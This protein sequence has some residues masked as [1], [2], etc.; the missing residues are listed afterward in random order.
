MENS[1]VSV[2]LVDDDEQYAKVVGHLLE[3]VKDRRFQMIWK[4][5]GEDGLQELKSN[6]AIDVV[7]MDYFLPGM[8][9]LE[10]VKHF[11]DHGITAP[12]IFLTTHKNVRVAVEAMK[13]GVEDYL[14]K[15]EATDDILS[16]TIL[17]VLER[18][19][20]QRQREKA[21]RQQLLANKRTEAVQQLVVAI[22]HEFNNPLAA[23]RISMDIISRKDRTPEQQA[24]LAKFNESVDELERQINKLRDM[25]EKAN[26]P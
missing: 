16:Q 1:A 4:A 8:N 19:R 22:C 9:G 15:D 3:K 7:L 24:L 14:V 20:V 18:V 12:V 6:P 11:G 10:I 5:S 13:Y 2:L 23:I 26:R 21:D 17:A 25:Q